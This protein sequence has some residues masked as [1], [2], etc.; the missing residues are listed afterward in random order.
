MN[1]DE[2]TAANHCFVVRLKWSVYL[3]LVV[4]QHAHTHTHISTHGV[5]SS[6]ARLHGLSHAAIYHFSPTLLWWCMFVKAEILVR[7]EELAVTYRPL[8][9]LP[10]KSR[11]HFISSLVLHIYC[12]Y[13]KSIELCREMNLLP[14]LGIVTELDLAWQYH[15]PPLKHV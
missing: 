2:L 12:N 8:V 1:L 9:C 15:T 14:A 4:Q 11:I 6:D 7:R 3:N 13:F 5:S 10:T